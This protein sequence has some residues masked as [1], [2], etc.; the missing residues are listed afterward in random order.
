MTGLRAEHLTLAYDGRRVIEDLTLALPPGAV[1]A[2]IGPNGCGKSTLLKALARILKPVSG[3]VTLDGR[4]LA[5]QP[6]R[7]L[8]RRLG[9]L[10]QAPL[11]P[12]G[13]TVADLVARGRAPWRGIFAPW[14]AA[15]EAARHA[16]LEATGTADLA[17]RPVAE[18]SGGQ[19]QR[20]WIA[21][22]LAQETPHLLLDEPTTWL[23]L[24]HQIEVLAL[25]RRLNREAGRSIVVVLHDLS[26]AAR[27]ADH[28]VLM[29][30]GRVQA[31]G[32]PADVLTPAALETAFGLRAEVIADPVHGTPLVL[33]L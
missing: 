26:L 33:P 30:A 24:A 19:R 2:I 8:A 15:D 6:T 28:L 17:A 16:A 1:T 21:L 9:L 22:A 10:P 23:D 12:E 32:S 29:R 14:S 7:M 27:F 5:A 4:D 20:V 13:I 31:T 25:L 3:R 18:L 11:A